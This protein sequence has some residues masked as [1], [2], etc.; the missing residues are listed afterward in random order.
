MIQFPDFS[1]L[2]A[3]GKKKPLQITAQEAVFGHNISQGA[4]G[5]AKEIANRGWKNPV[6]RLV[7]KSTAAAIYGALQ[8][9]AAVFQHRG[10]L[11]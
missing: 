9:I 2:Y 4:N 8:Q 5:L 10:S 11:R 7:R 6:D 1:V 3:S